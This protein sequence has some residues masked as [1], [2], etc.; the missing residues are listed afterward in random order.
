MGW[1]S[2]TWRRGGPKVWHVPRNPGRTY[3]L[4]GY[5]GSLAG[6]SQGRPKCLRKKLVLKFCCLVHKIHAICYPD[7]AAVW[8]MIHIFIKV[9]R[10]RGRTAHTVGLR[11][12]THA[13]CLFKN[14]L[15]QVESN[16]RS[17]ARNTKWHERQGAPTKRQVFGNA[18]TLRFQEPIPETRHVDMRLFC[19]SLRLFSNTQRSLKSDGFPKKF[20]TRSRFREIKRAP[21]WGL[22][23]RLSPRIFWCCK[24]GFHWRSCSGNLHWTGW[25]PAL[26]I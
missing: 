17:I 4:A 8:D 3:V 10:G 9:N 23:F 5:P 26:E 20:L 24:T 6:I 7:S 14:D 18:L 25:F 1:E 12:V 16:R 15:P 22:A 19:Y 11:I 13:L 21:V 2:S